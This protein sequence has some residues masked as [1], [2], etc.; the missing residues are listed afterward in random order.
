MAIAVTFDGRPTVFGNMAVVTGTFTIS[1]TSSAEV[2]DP[3]DYLSVVHSITVN[4]TDN[5]QMH[6]WLTDSGDTT[7][8]IKAAAN[9]KSGLF[10]AIG[11]R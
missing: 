8:N 6:A 3:S 10:M 4:G 5:T 2:L 9:D 7:A 1:G 11:Q